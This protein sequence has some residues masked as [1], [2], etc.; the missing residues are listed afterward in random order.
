MKSG[1]KSRQIWLFVS[2]I[3]FAGAIDVYAQ[4]A[5][6][7]HFT[8]D[9]GLPTNLIYEITQDQNGFLWMAT[10]QGLSRFDGHTFKNYRHLPYDSTSLSYD[11]VIEVFEA[12]D[13]TLWVGTEVGLN[14]FIPDTE[15]FIHHR[16]D[17]N[18]PTSISLDDIT[19]IHQEA[20]GTLWVGT[21]GGGLNR[22]D[23]DSGTFHHYRENTGLSNDVVNAIAQ[24][25]DGM[26][27]VG[28]ESGLDRLDPESGHISRYNHE[29]GNTSSLSNDVVST[30][31]VTRDGALLVGTEKGLNLYNPRT[32]SFSLVPAHISE[33]ALPGNEKVLSMYETSKGE[34]WIGTGRGIRR[35]SADFELLAA[36]YHR[37]DDPESLSRN[38]VRSIF[39]SRDGT[40]WI[41]TW[42][43]LS[44]YRSEGANFK[45]Y[46]PI[47]YGVTSND[48]RTL[49]KTQDNQ[50]WAGT[51]GGGMHQFDETSGAY[52]VYPSVE[53]GQMPLNHNVVRNLL[54]TRD[55]AFWIGTQGGGLNKLDRKSGRLTYYQ[56]QAGVVNSLIH[57]HV[58]TL[59]EANDGSLLIGSQYK[60][61]SKFDP[62]TETFTNNYFDNAA[63]ILSD[64]TI[65]DIHEEDDGVFWIASWVKGLHRYDTSTDKL[66]TYR[67]DPED[68]TSL[69]D[70]VVWAIHQA[71]DGTLW[72]GTNGGLERVNIGTNDDPSQIT[73]TAFSSQNT[74]YSGGSVKGILEDEHGL[75][76]LG[77][78]NGRLARFN[79][80]T[81][82]YRYFETLSIQRIGS[83]TRAATIGSNGDM[84]FGGYGGVIGFD[85]AQ[86][87]A[88]A[89]PPRLMLTDLKIFN[90]TVT[91]GI[92]SPLSAPLS[93]TKSVILNHNQNDLSIGFTAFEYQNPGGIRF[94]YRLLPYDE[95]WR[96]IT[97]QRSATY[98]SLSPGKYTFELQAANGDGIWAPESQ[99][100]SI[101]IRPPW[102]F[103]VWAY[104]AYSLLGVLA[105]RALDRLRRRRLIQ[106]E[107][108]R[109]RERELEQAKQLKQ[110]YEEL[111]EAHASLEAEKQK[112]EEQAAQL[113]ELDHAKSR[114]FANVS[115]EFRTPLTLTI[116]PLEDLQRDAEQAM[117]PQAKS[118]IDLALRNAYRV[119]DLINEILDVA[120]LE[121]GRL[122]LQASEQNLTAFV[123]D[124]SQAFAALA[125]RKRITYTVEKSEH[126]IA[127]YFDAVH[128]E[129][130][131]ANLLSNAFKFTPENGTILVTVGK[132]T[133]GQASKNDKVFFAV[134]DNGPGIPKAELP[135]V[136]DRFHQV[137]ESSMRLQPGTG[138]GLALVKQLVDRHGGEIEVESEA[139]FGSNFTVILQTGKDHFDV[140]DLATA[141]AKQDI[142]VL[143]PGAAI[144]RAERLMQESEAQV[145]APADVE[146][147]EDV[148]TVLVVEDNAEVRAYVSRHLAAVY[149]V[150]EA[151]NGKEGLALAQKIL[152]DLIV[153]DVMMP[154][155]DGH[156]LCKAIKENRETTFIPV[157]LLTA[158][159]ASE[160]KI[161][162]LEG[163]ADDYVTKPFDIQEL[164]ARVN[165][166]ITSR[167]Q[168]LAHASPGKPTIQIGTVEVTSV[169]EAFLEQV[170]DTIESHIGDESFSVEAMAD[171]LN[172][173]RSSL[174]RRLRTLLGQSP[175]EV[176]WTLRLERAA[177]LLEAKAGSVSEI[178]YSVG[179]KSVAHFSRRFQK[180]FNVSPSKYVESGSLDV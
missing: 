164:T 74:N 59:H 96:G 146:A 2:L 87:Q 154:E 158:R 117:G 1:Y 83:F 151:P 178:A 91:P 56:H 104:V 177:Q 61:V 92:D 105:V 24:T 75:L 109:T 86:I 9:D 121:S 179:F 131:I 79:P 170:R 69:G 108:E 102:W 167:Q 107:R 19:T 82:Y 110:A 126:P 68:S 142:A 153:S 67:H 163:G 144:Q 62:V 141:E 101:H 60:G 157:I 175:A 99:T 130:V 70:N 137:D 113:K 26:L 38:E 27:W 51:M 115:H 139:G 57:D 88:Q 13:G 180:H 128:L 43:G 172:M 6:F 76:W 33:D 89:A 37:A 161:E 145:D 165:N 106:Q 124:R 84:Y 49:Y 155:M 143:Q 93:K 11:F 90:E 54:E 100:L 72:L 16:H 169:D 7:E 12:Q 41:G 168:L 14:Q 17:E 136:F 150:I 45:F 39:E 122:K 8:V 66:T 34:I 162:G 22:Y 125:E 64:A 46:Q 173:D 156:A 15:T 114:F 95:A 73:F 44:R 58:M 85:P 20:D 5:S 140:V 65:V 103:S 149:R 120:K 47:Q 53:N 127:A 31:L 63:G 25:S 42:G 35:Y 135:H 80:A 97:E 23:A 152:P 98:T 166:L 174:F 3:F 36:Y 119:L 10:S 32:E 133:N 28:T 171:A 112:T 159:A 176:I 129:K 55:G 30:L 147:E 134:R 29:S 48:V 40:I 77:L 50:M 4:D 94:N 18:D 71:R 111:G 132:Y 81:R 138:I 78:M 160:D 52:T 21:W 148:T 118:Q 123:E 116:G